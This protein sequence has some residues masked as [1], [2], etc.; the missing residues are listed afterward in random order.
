MDDALHAALGLGA[1]GDDVAAG[2]HRD[3]R[4]TD[5]PGHRRSSQHRVEALAH[6]FLRCAQPL[7]DGCEI[8]GGGVEDLA[9]LVD[10]PRDP[11]R[12]LRRRLERFADAGQVRP[13][14]CLQAGPESIGR[15]ERLPHLEELRRRQASAAARPLE[16]GTDVT[17]PADAGLC[18]VG[19]EPVCLIGLVLEQSHVR[20]VRDRLGC[21]R[22][23]TRRVERGVRGQLLDDRPELERAKRAG[24]RGGSCRGLSDRRR[25]GHR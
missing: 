4:L 12:E 13:A 8:R 23:L 21:E 25:A 9:A 24:V 17:R 7:A 10:A 14:P 6:A 3:D 22:Q 19:Q 11:R 5:D 18:L 15:H 20:L 1:N 16:R 2:T